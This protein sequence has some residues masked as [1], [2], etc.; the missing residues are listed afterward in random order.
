MAES[1]IYNDDEFCIKGKSEIDY[2]A[3]VVKRISC[4]SRIL[5]KIFDTEKKN[6]FDYKA[7]GVKWKNCAFT[8][9]LF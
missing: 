2:K 4:A 6:K 7:R 9:F 1:S 8:D 3:H 5:H